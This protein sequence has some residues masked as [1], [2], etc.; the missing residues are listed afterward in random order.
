MTQIIHCKKYKADQTAATCIA[1]HRIIAKHQAGAREFYAQNRLSALQFAGCVGCKLGLE[2]YQKTLEEKTMQ[3]VKTCNDCKKTLPADKD[4]FDKAARASD[5]LTNACKSC[6]AK[7]FVKAQ[8]KP[9]NSKKADLRR[10]NTPPN[11][12]TPVVQDKRDT[13]KKNGTDVKICDYDE[14]KKEFTRREDEKNAAWANRKY[15]CP[16]CARKADQKKSNDR[17]RAGVRALKKGFFFDQERAAEIAHDVT[18]DMAA[19]VAPFVDGTGQ[20]DQIKA[21]AERVGIEC[22]R[23]MVGAA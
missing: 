23:R 13:S 4:H 7:V 10:K 2:L 22:Q 6:R 20:L 17:K 3:D 12:S 19:M 8:G 15:C 18:E 16:K 5:G 1:R 21:V 9:K 11:T 14:C